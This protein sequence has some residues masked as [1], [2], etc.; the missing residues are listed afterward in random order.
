MDSDR[1]P[2]QFKN[3]NLN[4]KAASK[5]YK[6]IKTKLDLHKPFKTY[7]LEPDDIE[8]TSAYDR[9]VAYFIRLHLRD[10]LTSDHR[11]VWFHIQT[12][13]LDEIEERSQLLR[14]VDADIQVTYSFGAMLSCDTF[15][16][17]T[18]DRR[19]AKIFIPRTFRRAIRLET[20][21]YSMSI[22]FKNI[23]PQILINHSTSDNAV[24]VIFMLKAPPII[25]LKDKQRTNR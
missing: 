11:H 17:H 5:I 24:R 1:V 21:A 22:H 15:V 2:C 25:T 19:L 14:R 18:N 23:D 13:S 6:N 16:G 9:K 10:I 3:L 20:S 4:A 7:P 12:K 8:Q